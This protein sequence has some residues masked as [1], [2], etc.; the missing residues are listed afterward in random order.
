[1][2]A[3]HYFHKVPETISNI[4]PWQG[5]SLEAN[6]RSGKVFESFHSYAAGEGFGKLTQHLTRMEGSATPFIQ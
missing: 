1:M 3:F 6:G 2:F 5:I 4:D